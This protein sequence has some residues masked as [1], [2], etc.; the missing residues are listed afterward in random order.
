[1]AKFLMACYPV[2]GHVH[3][4]I[5][6]G[7]ALRERG[8]EVAIYS[9][10]IARATVEEEGFSYFPF[11]DEVDKQ[12]TGALL[13]EEGP[14]FAA[15][16]SSSVSV[17]SLTKIKRVKKTLRD[18]FLSSVPQQVEDLRAAIEQ[19]QPDVL[20]TD[21]G[22]FGPILILHETEE[23]PVAVFCVL[24][25]CSLPGSDAPTWGR[26]LPPPRDW[27]TRLRSRLEKIAQDRILADFRAEADALRT[28]YGLKPI[29]G[30][31][32]EFS[33]QLPLYL[34]V[35][36]PEFDYNRSDLPSSVHYVGP[37]LWHRSS[38]EQPPEWINELPDDR[39]IVYV[40]EGTIHTK[41]PFVLQAA[42]EGLAHTAREV[43]MT[44]GKRRDPGILAVG[45]SAAN[46]R[47]ERYVPHGDLFPHTDV[48][49]TTGGAGTVLTALVAGVPLVVVPTGLDLPE[50]AQRVVEAGVG[51]RIHPKQCTPE[52]LRAA[53]EEVLGNSAYRRRAREIGTALTE[54]GGPHRA[55][56][57]LEEL[58]NSSDEAAVPAYAHNQSQEPLT[59]TVR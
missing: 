51:V 58:A 52:N 27:K 28:R 19:W 31:V 23:V 57:L 44:T 40:T 6:V 15:D 29:P 26:G 4:N 5:A 32:T 17:Q 54:Q 49:V 12:I 55:A 35:G 37:C 46:I 38:H 39:P 47:V 24:P 33:G 8:H 34:V 30:S 36:T 16:V 10:S 50:I 48:V 2:S 22:L 11:G 14:S 41:R 9:G 20:V 43:I 56:Q 42:A 13:P 45:E 1:M 7:Q 59:Q 25:A 18:W 53:V 3:P 21:I